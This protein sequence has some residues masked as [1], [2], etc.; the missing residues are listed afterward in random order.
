[1]NDEITQDA[2]YCDEDT[3]KNVYKNMENRLYF[4]L[5]EEA[6]NIERLINKAIWVLS[7]IITK[8]LLKW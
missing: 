4:V 3:M 7:K 1:M 8:K 2:C 5:Q 6:R